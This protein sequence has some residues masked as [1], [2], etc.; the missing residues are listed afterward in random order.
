MTSSGIRQKCSGISRVPVSV[1]TSITIT[2]LTMLV[3]SS[4]NSKIILG[5]TISSIKFKKIIRNNSIK[6]A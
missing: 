4:L 5:S 3:F 6:L 1:G 2:V